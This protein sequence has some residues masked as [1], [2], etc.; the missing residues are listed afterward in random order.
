MGFITSFN[1]M[2][3]KLSDYTFL[4]GKTIT[5]IYYTP[6]SEPIELY[7]TCGYN[8]NFCIIIELDYNNYFLL[9]T[10]NIFPSDKKEKLFSITGP[11][12][13]FENNWDAPDPEDLFIGRTPTELYIGHKIKAVKTETSGYKEIY[14]L[15]D[16]DL[17]VRHNMSSSDSLYIGESLGKCYKPKE[18]ESGT[19]ISSKD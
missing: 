10:N 2:T 1:I 13:G 3:S 18:P 6:P 14:L 12:Y 19:P 4:I 7:P 5:N 17:I 8:Y 11:L 15:L 16:N 9:D